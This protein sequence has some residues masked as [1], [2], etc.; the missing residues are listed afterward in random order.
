MVTKK[1]DRH[2]AK[3]LLRKLITRNGSPNRIVTDK[4]GS[5]RSAL[6]ELGYTG[7]HDTARW[8]NNSAENSHQPFRRRERSMQW[9]R[10]IGS[11]QKFVA[12][13]SQVHNHFNHERHLTGRK[14]FKVADNCNVVDR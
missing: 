9:F 14:E 13:H 8:R 7:V 6:R 12:I 10:L 1:R 5:Y 11:L 4:L 2:A 3:A